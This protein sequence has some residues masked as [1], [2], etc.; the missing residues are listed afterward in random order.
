MNIVQQLRMKPE[1]PTIYGPLDFRI[2]R[3]QLKEIDSLLLKSGIENDFLVTS[4]KEKEKYLKHLKETPNLPT[5]HPAL[6]RPN[7]L[8]KL[9]IA[10]RVNII[11]RLLNESYRDL[12]FRLADSSVCQWFIGIDTPLGGKT[13]GKSS[14]ERYEKMWND[15]EISSLIVNLN[16]KLSD[17]VNSEFLIASEKA[18]DFTHFYADSTCIESNIHHPVDWLLLRDA[19]RTI[20]A[21][22]LTIRNQGLFH[23]IATPT[24]FMSTMNSLTMAMT[25]ASRSRGKEGKKKQKRAFREMKKLFRRVVDH[26][27]RYREMLQNRWQETEW[28]EKQMLLVLNRMKNILEQADDI[29]RL[30]NDRIITGKIAK[31]HEKILSLYEKDVHVLKRGKAQGEVEFGNKLYIAEQEN[32]LIVDWDFFKDKQKSDVKILK[33]SVKRI[34]SQFRVDSFSADRGFD[35]EANRRILEEKGTFNAICPKA[36][37]TLQERILEQQFRNEQKRRAQTEG[38]IGIIKGVFIGKKILRKGFKNREKKV[39]WSIL[40]HN[41]WVTARIAIQN[42][43][44]RAKVAA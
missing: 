21:S 25:E 40:T 6:N 22:I 13:P 37:S 28:T 24:K 10:F 1:I 7:N 38:R 32:G 5:D 18:L 31:N 9:S 27:E 29:V 15:E 3:D 33:E 19:T 8:Q 26:G 23:R 20:I 41:L 36:P 2:F 34:E 44:E 12:A 30:A 4:L 17:D 43:E 14:I 11:N 16:E 35:S 42:R 39:V